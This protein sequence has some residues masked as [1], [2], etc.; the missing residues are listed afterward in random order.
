VSNSET[1]LP[2]RPTAG[3]NRRNSIIVAILLAGTLLLS[4]LAGFIA[5]RPS[6]VGEVSAASVLANCNGANAATCV[7]D[8]ALSIAEKSGPAA[9]LDAVRMLLE[10]RPDIREG[11][12]TVAH[13][14]GN[15]FYERFGEDAIV[16]GH[17]WCSWGYY[18][19]L[20]QTHSEDSTDGLVDYATD[21]CSK[22]DG[23]LTT[24]CMHGVGHAA[25]MAL[26]QIGPSLTVCE[27][28]TGELAATCADAVI[29]EELFLSPNGRLTSGFSPDDCLVSSNEDV[30]T[31]CARGLASDH[32][33]NG[34]DL[35]SSCGMFDGKAYAACV[36]GY[37]SSVAGSELSGYGAVSQS[38]IDSCAAELGC[39]TGYGWI[40][41][42]YLIDTVR[43]E[44]ACQR[45]FTGAGLSA[46]TTSVRNAASRETLK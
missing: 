18:H 24:D 3:P 29:M 16:P 19:G 36:D 33:Q 26:R 23:R 6:G 8:S 34:R 4:G 43:A 12:H 27:E 1:R 35:V 40:A 7:G 38:M 11:C 22:V 30:V 41:Y 13:A 44:A 15:R 42:M 32:V 21:L 28:L 37:G 2:G 20:M 17:T 5:L 9:G 25:Y 46:C 39:T 31:G 10:T 45:N 14:V